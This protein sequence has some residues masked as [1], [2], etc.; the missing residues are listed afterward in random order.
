[1]PYHALAAM[2]RYVRLLCDIYC[3]LS[4]LLRIHLVTS[5]YASMF[6]VVLTS[7]FAKDGGFAEYIAA[8]PEDLVPIPEG[9]SF[10]LGTCI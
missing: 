9:V 10:A 5:Y 7:G 4:A 3:P 2:S 1:M 8:L 6:G